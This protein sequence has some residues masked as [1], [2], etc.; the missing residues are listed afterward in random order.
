MAVSGAGSTALLT[1]CLLLSGAVL[2]LLVAP[3]NSTTALLR[4][5]NDL[6]NYRQKSGICKSIDIRNSLKSFENLRGCQ[7]V[8]GFV[9]ILLFDNINESEWSNISFPELRE[10]TD[11]LLL[12]RVNGLRTL[13]TLFPSLAVI[14]GQNTFYNHALVLFEMPTLQE[15]GLYSLTDITHGY[16]RIDKNPLLCYLN[17]IDWDQITYE[18]GDHFIKNMKPDNECPLCPEGKNCSFGRLLP[19]KSSFLEGKKTCWNKKH[20]QKQCPNGCRT[21][22]NLGMCCDTNC[23]GGC[24][25]NNITKCHVCKNISIG[26]GDKRQCSQKCPH[27][28]LEYL[29]RR[30]ISK[31]ECLNTMRPID[32]SG[33]NNSKLPEKPYKVFNGTCI[34]KCPPNYTDEN[35][36]CTLCKGRCKKQ[37]PGANIDSAQSAED[38]RGCT[39]I[40][41]SLEIQIRGGKNIVNKLE[42]NLNMIEE[43][44]GYLKI[45]RSFPLMTLNFLKNLKIIWGNTLESNKY[46]FVVLDNQNLQELWNNDNHTLQIK[47]G[48]LFFHFNPKLCLYKIQRLQKMANLDEAT[49]LEVAPNSNGDKIACTVTELKVNVTRHPKAVVLEW[50]TF[51]GGDFRKLLGYVVYCIEA[52]HRNITLYDGRDA[53][54]GDGWRVDDVSINSSDNET[55]VTHPLTHLKPNMQYAYF[56]KTYS[57]SSENYSAESTI[58]YFRTLSDEPSVIED[59]RVISNS[60]DSFYITWDLPR[61]PNGNITHY[62]V[63]G[64]RKNETI[65]SDRISEGCAGTSSFPS[66]PKM[67]LPIKTD[68]YSSKP[69]ND[70][71]V[72]DSSKKSEKS[73]PPKE[74][75][76]MNQIDFENALQNTVYK[77]RN[78]KSSGRQKRDVINA[79]GDQD[80]RGESNTTD[81][82]SDNELFPQ[83]KPKAENIVNVDNATINNTDLWESFKFY[84]TNGKTEMYINKLKHYT[85]Y[86]ITV[87]VCRESEGSL[88]KQPTCSKASSPLIEPRTQ[89]KVGANDIHFI[90]V[91][92]QSVDMVVITWKE[93]EDPNGELL[94]YRMEYKRLDHDHANPH[95][96]CWGHKAF[97]NASRLY[98]LRNLS[99][100]NYS[101]KVMARTAAGGGKYSP[102]VYFYIEESSTTSPGKVIIAV[103]MAIL[104][105]A[106]ITG[107]LYYKRRQEQ[108]INNMKLIPKIN[109]DYDVYIPDEWEVSRKKIDFLKEL[110]QGSFGMVYEG[111]AKDIRG[112]P[113]VRCAIKTVNEHATNRE[114]LEFLNEATV[115]K[116][117]DTHHVVRLLGVVS[118]G[119]PTLVVMELMANGDLKSYLRSHRPDIDPSIER[120]PPTLKQILQMA[121]EIADGMAYLAAKKFV[122]RDLAA[123]NCMVAEDLTVKIGDFGMT[124]DIYETD[125]YRK[126]TKGLLP[127]RWMAPESLK[128]GVFTSSSDVWSYGVVLWEM[129]TLASQP[130]QGLSNDQVLRYVIDGGIMEAPENCP[131]KLYKLMRHCW[132]HK[133]SDRPTF[134][135]LC[136]YLID[137]AS[138]TF[139]QVSFYHSPQ[140]VEAR[141][142]RNSQSSQN[143][144]STPLRMVHDLDENSVTSSDHDSDLDIDMDTHI[145]FPSFPML[146]KEETGATANGYVTGHPTGG[147]T[148]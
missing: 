128:D 30:C 56:V 147:T 133:P 94:N 14:R 51:K 98:T 115:M 83:E 108:N 53:C 48:R 87:Q 135:E 69:K 66:Q 125:Y 76:I 117:F 72:C 22:N 136:T 44:D 62:I 130:Y 55:K 100:G 89:E 1:R 52:P 143:D 47:N 112:K 99:P 15:I 134:L 8:E 105:I 38:L 39:H 67:D 40:N 90:K 118:Q 140:G 16:V 79:P 35:R 34:I 24:D 37:C 9:Q 137:D 41:G 146:S 23:L 2:V 54:G 144:P 93:P 85:V 120:T 97:L 106:G 27:G 57:I 116:E 142:S 123:R 28:T 111:L 127:V 119:Q 29:D 124:R 17:T 138:E 71:C 26:D 114:R 82:Y 12:Y 75:E 81:D 101:L 20:C 126:G 33:D 46:V 65:S 73:K 95:E 49:E 80:S 131:E 148:T 21:C 110:G 145:D 13:E 121:I 11:F 61:N 122:H 132:K 129:A 10:I 50:N 77:K 4:P 113:E 7:V 139:R 5:K 19:A 84:I 32:I 141:S 3:Y 18:Q 60:S 96:R 64:I 59:I 74:H 109:P 70:T 45:V 107:F 104:L 86:D 102:Y 68:T 43:I 78:T 25:D 58:N 31:E 92:N 103:V 88:D 6:V 42:E 91:H 36:T 63:T